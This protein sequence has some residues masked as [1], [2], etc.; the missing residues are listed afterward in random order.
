MSYAAEHRAARILIASADIFLAQLR[1]QVL[2]QHFASAV[3][4]VSTRNRQHALALLQSEDFQ[5]L[6]LCCSLTSK[7]H[8]E[9]AELYRQRNSTGKLVVCEGRDPVS[10][11]YDVMLPIP[12]GPCELLAAM[13]AILQQLGIPNIA[14]PE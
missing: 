7:A 12:G 9:F 10:F 2:E 13:R 14:N 8:T 1:K 11:T 6:L 5:V 3:D 4:V